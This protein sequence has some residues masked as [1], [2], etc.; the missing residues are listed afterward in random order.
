MKRM[1][2]PRRHHVLPNKAYLNGFTTDGLLWVFDRVN[3]KFLHLTPKA[4]AVR[5]DYYSFVD[6]LGNKDTTIE[7]PVL[8]G[9]EGATIPVIRKLEE[10]K[11]ISLDDRMVLSLFVACMFLR[12]PAFERIHNKIGEELHRFQNRFIFSSPEKIREMLNALPES[13]KSADLATAEEIFEFVQQAD[14]NVNFHRN[15][16]LEMMLGL[17]IEFT[18]IFAKLD[19]IVG[20][21][22]DTA[23]FLTTDAPF[24]ISPPPG[25]QS[26]LGLGRGILVHG[27]TKSIALSQRLCLSM[28]NPGSFFGHLDLQSDGVTKNNMAFASRA[29]RFIISPHEAL[30]KDVVATLGLEK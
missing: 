21:S 20:H 30:L 5:N 4:T 6:A 8:S 19:W 27:A 14:Y 25:H 23:R 2:V 3:K 26:E 17:A 29:E 16:S 28:G 1:S 12:T 9:I 18:P 11:E 24:V 10:R 7:N 15:A 13:V 22:S